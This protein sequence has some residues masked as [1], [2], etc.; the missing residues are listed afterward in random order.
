MRLRDEEW[1]II[2]TLLPGPRVRKDGKGRP[3]R[4]D[5]GVLDGILWVLKTGARW[6]DL[7]SNYPPYQ[8]CHRR[9]QQWQ[10]QGVIDKILENIAQKLFDD[11]I[12]NLQEASIDGSF[13]AAKKG[14]KKSEKP[15]K[16]RV[17]KSWQLQRVTVFLSE[18]PLKV[19][20]HMRLRLLK[21]QLNLSTL[22]VY[23]TNLSE[24][25][26]MILMSL[27]RE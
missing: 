17:L 22:P 27:T 6:R 24:T 11:G 15:K 25:K 13:A 21:K 14:A 10:E 16:A 2:Q 18:Y 3:R 7:P 9:F 26:H 8:T 19:L 1:I 12:L 23:Q 5:R 4:D 20:H